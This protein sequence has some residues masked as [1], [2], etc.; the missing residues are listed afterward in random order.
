MKSKRHER[1]LQ[2]IVEEQ[3]TTQEELLSRLK[4]S[5]FNV[6]QATVSRDIKEL[7]LLKT[8]SEDGKYRYSV[9]AENSA[10]EMKDKYQSIMKQSIK[11]VDY[12]QNIAVLKCYEGMANAACAA[13][14]MIFAT[15]VVGT[16]AGDDTIFILL[17]NEEHAKKF[18]E[19]IK[20]LYL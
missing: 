13:V 4:A 7:K 11:G 3:I 20:E 16:L 9:S 6:T 18:T 5:G 10:G 17:R 2:L 15:E 8:L 1:I 12:A 19:A 14:D